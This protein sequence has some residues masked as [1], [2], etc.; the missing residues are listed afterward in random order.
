MEFSCT[1]RADEGRKEEDKAKEVN[2]DL[3]KGDNDE[4]SKKRELAAR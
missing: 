4:T 2:G 3:K 1:S